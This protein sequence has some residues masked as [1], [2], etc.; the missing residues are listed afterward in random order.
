[1]LY[2]PRKPSS[3]AR[4]A[5]PAV[6]TCT[7]M[8]CVQAS[9]AH[10]YHHPSLRAKALT[11]SPSQPSSWLSPRVYR[12]DSQEGQHTSVQVW[13]KTFMH[14]STHA[15]SLWVGVGDS[16]QQELPTLKFTSEQRFCFCWHQRTIWAKAPQ[17]LFAALVSTGHILL[18][19]WCSR[20]LGLCPLNF[21]SCVFVLWDAFCCFATQA[22]RTR[23]CIWAASR[24]PPIFPE[25]ETRK[26]SWNS[27]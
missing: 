12:W 1:M 18:H 21:F 17:W 19:G 27:L 5:V 14:S 9:G 2:W 20:S 7:G 23:F 26:P 8:H 25:A 10:V 16:S 11:E 6:P 4:K 24:T 13:S 15:G 22:K 3:P